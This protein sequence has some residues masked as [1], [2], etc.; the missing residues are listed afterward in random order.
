MVNTSTTSKKIEWDVAEV[1]EYDY[2]YQYVPETE[3]NPTTNKLFA[4]K[5]RSCSTYYNDKIYIARPSNI[6]MKQIPLVGEFVLIYKTFNQESTNERW[7][8]AWYY[9]SSV[10]IQSSIN[11]NMLPG[12]SDGKQQESIDNVQPGKTF[13]KRA[14]S[15]LQ[16]FEGDFLIEGRFGN[17]I[18]FGSSVNTTAAPAGYYNK[19]TT[20]RSS[21][22]S[23]P[24]IILSNGRKNLPSKEFVV[25]DIEQDFASLYLTSTQQLDKLKLSTPLT[26]N[27]NF[28]GSQFIGAADRIILRAKTDIVVIDS[29]KEIVLNTLGNIKLGDDSADQSMVHGEV[30]IKI[31]NKMARAILSGGTA[32]GAIVNTNTPTLLTDISADLAELMSKKYKIKKT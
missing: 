14:I 24:I 23:S 22:Y 1:L 31:L 30:L 13:V 5:V 3:P 18:R 27:N 29:E 21:D 6:N 26:V 12:L 25:E 9:V 7:R 15:P 19:S 32:Q 28:V 11:E 8:E 10:D 16:P 20:W 17:S 4:L 2:T